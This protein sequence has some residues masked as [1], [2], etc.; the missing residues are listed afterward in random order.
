MSIFSPNRVQRYRSKKG[1]SLIEVLISISVISIA[2]LGVLGSLSYARLSS[3]QTLSYTQAAAFQRR[4]AEFILVGGDKG[5]YVVGDTLRNG[6]NDPYNGTW[7]PLNRFADVA[8]TNVT[9]PINMRDFLINDADESNPNSADYKAFMNA[10]DAGYEVRVTLTPLAAPTA[11]TDYKSRLCSVKT[12]VRWR[13]PNNK[14]RT[15]ATTALYRRST[16]Q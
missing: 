9:N 3:N 11:V 1:F 10:C 5:P 15:V 12:E 8:G 6:T 14:V 13:D 7:I 4:V 2:M 16:S